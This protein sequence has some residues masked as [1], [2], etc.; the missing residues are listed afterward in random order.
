MASSHPI[1]LDSSP[2]ASFAMLTA[3]E[4][5]MAV[6]T[7]VLVCPP[8]GWEEVASF[9]VRRDWAHR[10]AD[11]GHP[12][13]RLTL[14]ATGNSDGTPRDPELLDAWIGS[15]GTAATWLKDRLGAERVAALGLGLGGLLAF[16]GVARGAPI[17][18]LAIWAAPRSGRHFVRET[19]AFA[20]LQAWRVEGEEDGADADA[21]LGEGW[22]EAGGFLLSPE[23]LQALR[24]LR[25]Q[26]GG[27]RPTP[28]RV[29]ILGRDAVAPDAEL[30]E[31]LRASGAEAELAAGPGWGLMTSHPERAVLPGAVA[32]S[33]EGWLASG[34]A[35][36]ATERSTLS[37]AAFAEEATM[38]LA[39]GS[40]DETAVLLTQ[41]WGDAFGVLTEPKRTGAGLCAVFL[42]AGAVRSTGPSRLW[43]ETARGWAA[44][45]V[46]SMRIDLEGIGEADGEPG[47]GLRVGDF[48]QP[49]FGP[50][51]A[52]V[53]DEL[54]GRGLGSEFV[55]VGLCAGGYWAFRAAV[56]DARVRA[57]VLLNGGALR[58]HSDLLAERAARKAPRAFDRRQWRRLLAGRERLR[59]LR[60]V[61]GAV[62]LGVV[63]GGLFSSGRRRSQVVLAEVEADLDRLRE[64]ETEALIA[65]SEGEPLGVEV[66]ASGIPAQVAERWPN[67]ELAELPGK[68]HSLRPFAAQRAARRL[69]D[70]ELERL[71]QGAPARSA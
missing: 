33:L 16:E 61:I 9:R 15:I 63:R 56:E 36:S 30:A 25:F 58:W 59:K 50:Q 57:A 48:Y 23:T 34:Q 46:A 24:G 60:A 1:Y 65:F 14:P 38:A 21:G 13:L 29:L 47:G 53:L 68:D 54:A 51:L 28:S 5:D 39:D 12:T 2:H 71:L 44:R 67:V 70:E 64:S 55:L 3:P 18:D 32:A 45:G 69:L 62:L 41:P 7:P 31:Q 4:A 17:D 66:E 11:A 6:S 43:V 42:N 40:T 22:L 20:R 37:P 52:A 10:L 19:T 8:W 27:E 35:A 49:R 26:V